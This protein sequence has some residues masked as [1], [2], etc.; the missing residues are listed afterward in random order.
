MINLQLANYVVA[1][2]GDDWASE[3]RSSHGKLFDY[4]FGAG[5]V[6]MRA[7]REGLDACVP[8]AACEIR[9]LAPVEPFV[10]LSFPLVP[11]GLVRRM[12]NRARAACVEKGSPIEALFY[13][14]LDAEADEWTLTEPA[15]RATGGSVRPEDETDEDYRSALI[16]LHS[17]HQMEAFW[18]GDD[19]RDEQ[20]FRLYA[21]IG[22]IFTRSVLRV[23]VGC[24]GHFYEVPAREIFELP[25]GVNE[26][27][28]ANA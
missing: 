20:G 13:L 7:T 23:R 26:G 4:I 15:Q 9:G 25:A 28:E 10:N 27:G 14:R 3:R 21:V 11:A 12:F 8:V 2:P 17:H 18:S 19:D 22:E 1:H 5:G 6:F 24:Y 16:E